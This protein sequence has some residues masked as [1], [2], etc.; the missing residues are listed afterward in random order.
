MTQVAL[1][2]GSYLAGMPMELYFGLGSASIADEVSVTWADGTVSELG[3]I[4]G[5]RLIH[6]TPAGVE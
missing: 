6:V 1:Y 5:D 4:S 2:G 3:S